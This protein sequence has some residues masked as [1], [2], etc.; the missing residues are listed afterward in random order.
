MIFLLG[1]NNSLLTHASRQAMCYNQPLSCS[2]LAQGG[3]VNDTALTEV[4][5]RTL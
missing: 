4:C 2:I 3:E 5:D 1:Y